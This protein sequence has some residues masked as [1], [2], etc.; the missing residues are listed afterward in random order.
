MEVSLVEA[1]SVVV[2]LA[3]LIRLWPIR[4]GY[5]AFLTLM[6]FSVVTHGVAVFSDFNSKA[7]HQ[8]WSVSVVILV[9]LQVRAALELLR[10]WIAEYPGLRVPLLLAGGLVSFVAGGTFLA[11]W[12][13][14]SDPNQLVKSAR[15]FEQAAGTGLAIY[16]AIVCGVLRLLYPAARKNLRKHALLFAAMMVASAVAVWIGSDANWWFIPTLNAIYL[17]YLTL[18]PTGEI[19]LEPTRPGNPE[20]AY[21]AM[22]NS[23]RDGIIP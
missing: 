1:L 15:L 20:R 16:L 21:R 4:A 3:V 23:A 7:Y 12:P 14:S 19:P 17:G 18:S 10:R 9:A 22:A 5:A 8:F 11:Y 13:A 6:A 2:Q